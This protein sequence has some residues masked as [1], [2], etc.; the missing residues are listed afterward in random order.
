M[1]LKLPDD[2]ICCLPSTIKDPIR[3]GCDSDGGYIVPR[4][5]LDHCDDLLSFGLG[6]NWSFDRAWKKLKPNAKIHMYDGTVNINNMKDYLQAPYHEFFS[7]SAVHFIE[8]VGRKGFNITH[9]EVGEAVERLESQRIM[10]KIDIE[11]GEFVI[12]NDILSRRDIFPV[13]VIEIHFANYRRENF[14]QTI[15]KIK[16]Y[17][18]LVHTHGNNHTVLGADGSC[19]CFEFTFVRKDLCNDTTPRHEFYIDGLDFSN[20]PGLDDYEFYFEDTE[21]TKSKKK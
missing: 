9:T 20:V 21:P 12:L 13:I 4:M 16:E 15:E 17:Y 18:E 8:N 7:K 11:G 10:L 2:L 1:K 6:E 19:D 5:V 3:I 14:K